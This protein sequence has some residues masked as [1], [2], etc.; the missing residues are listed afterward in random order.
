MIQRALSNLLSN[1]LRF[2]PEGMPIEVGI[3]E[4]EGVASVTVAN[5]GPEIP[6]EHLPK[7]F[8]R[9]Y[10][11][12]ASRREGDTLN[13]GLGLAITKSIV[14]IHGGTVSAKAAKSRTHFTIALPL[15]PAILSDSERN[16]DRQG[17]FA[18][19]LSSVGALAQ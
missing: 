2:T 11:V 15:K 9:L 18:V 19:S 4:H 12:D 14:E 6:M 17:P 1:A 10:R 16:D 5:S 8:R 7:I 13:V 3:Q